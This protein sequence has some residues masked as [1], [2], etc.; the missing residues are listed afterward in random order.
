MGW[1]SFDNGFLYAAFERAKQT[2]DTFLAFELNQDPAGPRISG[3]IAV[4]HRSTGDV[5]ITYDIS[6]TNKVSVGNVHVE[7]AT[8]TPATG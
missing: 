2:G 7:T 8:R 4:P 6:T 5:L 3:G 1:S